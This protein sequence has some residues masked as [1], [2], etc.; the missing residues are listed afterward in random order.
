[1]KKFTRQSIPG[2]LCSPEAARK[3]DLTES[4]FRKYHSAIPSI[5][6]HFRGPKFFKEEDLN[7]FME[8]FDDTKEIFPA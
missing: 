1:M 7:K 5:Q 3:L 8:E 2:Y 4:Q 6:L